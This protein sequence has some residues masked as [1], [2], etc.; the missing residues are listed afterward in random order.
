MAVNNNGYWPYTLKVGDIVRFASGDL[1]VVRATSVGKSGYTTWVNFAIRRVSWTGRAYTAMGYVDL[2][3][4]GAKPVGRM[5]RLDLPL[6]KAME[7][8]LRY[9]NRFM[10]DQRIFAKDVIGVMP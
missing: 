5:K 7:E 1:R 9:E 3:Q 6:D 10:E 8:S 2:K 4:R